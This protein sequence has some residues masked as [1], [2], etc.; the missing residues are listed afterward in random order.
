MPP[1][2]IWADVPAEVAQKA[3]ADLREQYQP[4]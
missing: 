2:I 3:F 1:A 4:A